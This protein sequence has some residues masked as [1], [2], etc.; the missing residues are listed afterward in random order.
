M[1]AVFEAGLPSREGRRKDGGGAD[2]SEYR[3]RCWNASFQI[4]KTA[5]LVDHESDSDQAG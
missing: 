5:R 2:E 4:D 1:W 3:T